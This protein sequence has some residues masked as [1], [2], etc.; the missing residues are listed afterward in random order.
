IALYVLVGTF[1]TGAVVL[2][3]PASEHSDDT[4]R[5]SKHGSNVAQWISDHTEPLLVLTPLALYIND[6]AR[7]RN[8][9]RRIINAEVPAVVLTKLLKRQTRQ[10]RPRNQE[11]LSGF[12][13]GH[14][15][16]AWAMATV[17]A[18]QYPDYNWCAYLW[19]GAVTWARRGCRAHTWA[20]TLAGA[21]IGYGAAH[22]EL[23]QPDG[24]LLH[25]DP[26]VGQE[27]PSWTVL[28]P[29]QWQALTFRDDFVARL[30]LFSRSF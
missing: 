15:A 23:N 4:D 16:A 27:V 3:Q 17:L 21:A 19:A 5:P 13:S 22:W 8:A 10:P 6:S 9:A 26:P 24:L 30:K 20:Q 14:S 11:E 12:P 18:D 29:E 7:S 2:A 25:V 1:A 28:T